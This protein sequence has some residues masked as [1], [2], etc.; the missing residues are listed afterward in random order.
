VLYF[1]AYCN[2]IAI[3]NVSVAVVDVVVAVVQPLPDLTSHVY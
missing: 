1:N 2:L 3:V